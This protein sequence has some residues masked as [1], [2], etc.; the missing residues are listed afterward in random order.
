MA[1]RWGYFEDSVRLAAALRP[2]LAARGVP[3]PIYVDNGS[4][5]VDAA[6]KRAAARLGIK[7]THS[8]PGRPQGRGKIERFFGVVRGQFLV[9]I[10]DGAR[11]Q[12]PGG[13]EP[14]VHR[15]VR[16][17]STTPGRTARPG[18][19]RSDRWLAGGPF[20]IP[21]PARLREA[22]LWSEHRLVRKDATIQLFGGVY[23]TDPELAGRKVECVFDPFDL[24]VVE[25]RWNGSPT[26][27]GWPPRSRS[28]ATPIPKAKPR[29]PAR[30][31]AG[32]R[33][34]LHRHHR[35]RARRP[36]PAATVSATTPSPAARARTARTAASR[37]A[38]DRRSRRQSGPPR[39]A[40]IIGLVR[41]ADRAG[42][43]LA[44][45]RPPPTSPPRPPARTDRRRAR[46]PADGHSR[47]IDRRPA[48]PPPAPATRPTP[49]P[50]WPRPAP[51]P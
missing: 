5:F 3:V 36:P 42:P 1:A 20:P 2:A 30:A 51:P 40:P 46:R 44:P 29:T 28:A 8:A 23:E 16:D 34:R 32:D 10:G 6:L 17:G 26:G 47:D 12:G 35:R 19:R 18:S 49:P 13:A 50:C 11:R 39:S 4:A 22:F 24:T 9:E 15:L 41:A 38:S 33:H 48:R 45:P 37:R 21:S 27:P 43:A 31:A 7:I 14:A 25:I